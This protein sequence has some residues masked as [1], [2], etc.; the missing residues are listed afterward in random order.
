MKLGLDVDFHKLEAEKLKKGK[1]KVE[2]DL[3]SLKIDYKKLRITIKIVGLGKMSEQWRQEIK[4]EKT[5]ADHWEKRFQDARVR[6]DTLKKSLLE[7]QNEKE[8]L[9]AQVAKLERLLQQHHSHNSIIKLK[10]SLSRI[11]ELK[12]KIE[13]LETALQDSK[14]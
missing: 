10:A 8:K 13:E 5:R 12:G 4:E 14:I 7:T 1:N 9:R 3:D 2:E 6:E 11:E